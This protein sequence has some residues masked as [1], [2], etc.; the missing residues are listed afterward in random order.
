LSSMKAVFHGLSIVDRSL[1]CAR[2][3]DLLA[4]LNQAVYRG[5]SVMQ[6]LA[7]SLQSDS[8][9]DQGLATPLSSCR[10][11]LEPRGSSLSGIDSTPASPA[12]RSSFEVLEASGPLTLPLDRLQSA[13]E[14]SPLSAIVQQPAP[15]LQH[16]QTQSHC[17]TPKSL[18]RLTASLQAQ[19]QDQ[20]CP[21]TFHT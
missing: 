11:A 19:S 18:A 6:L 10:P 21:P 3:D 15:R 7:L 8:L 14:G 20:S 13:T 9:S 2:P 12:Q 17:S 16:G 1:L 5:R 4:Q